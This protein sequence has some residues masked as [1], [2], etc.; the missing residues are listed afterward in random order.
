MEQ[1]IYYTVQRRKMI[2]TGQ[3]RGEWDAWTDVSEA[4]YWISAHTVDGIRDHYLEYLKKKKPN[5][6]Y[7]VIKV[8]L[9][10]EEVKVI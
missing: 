1:T 4:T 5:E 8:T 7:R 6:E 2:H 3:Y 10:K 9:Q